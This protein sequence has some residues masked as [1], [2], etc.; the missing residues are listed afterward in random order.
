MRAEQPRCQGLC[1][2]AFE[3][4]CN[5]PTHGKRQSQCRQGVTGSRSEDSRRIITE[6]RPSDSNCRGRAPSEGLITFFACEKSI[7][8]TD[9]ITSE[10][11]P[12]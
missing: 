9:S 2:M 5:W 10:I 11:L 7:R 8:S 3:N 1:F 6:K 12:I 4:G